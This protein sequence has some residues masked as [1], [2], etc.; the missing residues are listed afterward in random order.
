MVWT[1]WSLLV[2][3][4]GRGLDKKNMYWVVKLLQ[5]EKDC[6]QVNSRYS[7]KLSV[8]FALLDLL[9]VL[10][11][12]EEMILKKMLPIYGVLMIADT[13]VFDMKNVESWKLQNVLKLFENILDYS[14]HEQSKGR[15][16][17]RRREIIEIQREH[18]KWAYRGR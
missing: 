18:Q 14:E 16:E 9:K 3:G 1:F 5:L 10:T 11:G 6:S 2:Q 7:G 13:N 8:T 17:K 15:R 12:K 4:L